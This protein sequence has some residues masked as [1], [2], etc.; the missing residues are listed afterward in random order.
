M[1]GLELI[2]T[3]HVLITL[4]L[5]Q[6]TKADQRYHFIFEHNLIFSSSPFAGLLWT[7]H[8]E[9][10]NFAN[11]LRQRQFKVFKCI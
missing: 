6:H 11:T 10:F 8:N 5:G 9:R 2:L 4:R 3:A 7:S 1:I